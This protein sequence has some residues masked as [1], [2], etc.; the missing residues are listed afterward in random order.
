MLVA[1]SD[2]HL[3]AYVEK[4][5]RLRMLN[6]LGPASAKAQKHALVFGTSDG[7]L[8]CVC[9]VDELVF[10]R[11]HALQTKM[12]NALPHFAGLN[13]KAWRYVKPERKVLR[14]PINNTL[15]GD[16]LFK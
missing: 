11:L 16:L 9:P 2:F 5:I 3:G 14:N 1:R 7:G 15:D 4:F 8:G 6:P 13:P 10:K 12:I